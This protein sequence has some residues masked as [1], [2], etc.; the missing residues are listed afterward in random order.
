M[1]YAARP[2]P[3]RDGALHRRDGHGD[4]GPRGVPA[5]AWDG[6]AQVHLL[7]HHEEVSSVA[8]GAE[9]GAWVSAQVLRVKG[10]QVCGLS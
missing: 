6:G 2:A 10:F 5:L 7:H 4:P 9:G 8:C 3:H 1:L